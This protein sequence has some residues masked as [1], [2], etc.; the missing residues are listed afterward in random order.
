MVKK[1]RRKTKTTR[2][3][4]VHCTVSTHLTF[5]MTSIHK[6]ESKAITG[7]SFNSLTSLCFITVPL[8][9]CGF[10]Y[11]SKNT[12]QKCDIQGSTDTL[13]SMGDIET[14]VNLTPLSA[15]LRTAGGTQS[16]QRT[17]TNT[18]KTSKLHTGL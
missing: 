3:S 2:C 9:F 6:T 16:T 14:P 1:K 8:F 5:R 7:Y 11:M 13:T 4:L 10:N 18:G 12:T 17:H 15:C